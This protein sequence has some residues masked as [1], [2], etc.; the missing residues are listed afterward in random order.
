MP[1]TFTLDPR[2]EQDTLQLADLDLC[3]VR[4]MNDARFPWLILVPRA[5]G[6]TEIDQL[7]RTQRM[8]LLDEMERCG[9]A[10]RAC[11]AVDKLNIGALGNI[12]QQ[13]HVHVV[14]RT[15]GDEAWPGPVWGYGAPQRYTDTQADELLDLLAKQL[16]R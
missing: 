6:L 2:L 8:Q 13:L 15:R 3:R 1:D 5:P 14:A 4:L 11:A 9:H 16:V 10:L 12:V 7:D